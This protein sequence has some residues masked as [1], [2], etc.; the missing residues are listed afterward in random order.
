[1]PRKLDP[2]ALP[3]GEYAIVEA[4]GHRTLVGRIA[5]AQRYGVV[6]LQV[7]P[8]YLEWMLDPVLL[9]GSSIY[10]LTPCSPQ[11]AWSRRARYEH[12]LPSSLAATI[13]DLPAPNLPA[14]LGYDAGA[15]Q[16]DDEDFADAPA[17]SAWDG[18]L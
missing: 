5:E 18:D 14:F 16:D 10:Q 17:A 15:C 9:G 7:E 11:A 6:M 4:L 8:I 1:M 3:D 2:E 13:A 12:E